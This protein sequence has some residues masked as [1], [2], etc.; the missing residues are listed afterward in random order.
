MATTTTVLPTFTS[1]ERVLCFHGPLL[2]E[3]KVL[4]TKTVEN[5]LP[6]Q[7]GGPQYFVHYKGWK[8]TW[9]EWVPPTRLLKMSEE[10]L[11]RQKQLQLSTPGAG[12]GG[13]GTGGISKAG[14]SKSGAGGGSKDNQ[15]ARAGGRKDGARGTKRA[16]EDDDSTRKPEMKLNIPEVL[17]ARLIDDWEAVTKNNQ[18]VEVPRSP[19]VKEV[20]AQFADHCLTTQPSTLR[21]SKLLVQ[22]VIDGLQTYFDRALGTCL[23][24]R[25]ER[26]QYATVRRTYY[27]GQH[28]IVG[29]T[30]KE[31]S[32]IY[33]AEHLLRM[34]VNLPQMISQTM[35][36][37]DSVNL[38]RDY[39]NELMTW[40]IQEQD[41]IFQKEYTH[42]TPE[43]QN[44]SRS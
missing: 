10:N 17:K 9:D 13:S 25:F 41:K 1:N 22:T 7:L 6:G 31:M 27:T 19:N 29:Q 44:L 12:H 15:S 11:A 16:R 34:L 30:E 2:Y 18:L 4:K 14:G 36:D 40:M 20:L 32:E 39:A 43:Y 8:Q 38:I 33:G 37:S 42:A 23:L 5:P 35:L 24:Y 21:E 3:A 28:V 26:I